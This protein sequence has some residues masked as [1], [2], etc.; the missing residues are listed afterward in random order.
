MRK[1]LLNLEK[2]YMEEMKHSMYLGSVVNSI[3]LE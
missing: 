3:Y 1:E 2:K